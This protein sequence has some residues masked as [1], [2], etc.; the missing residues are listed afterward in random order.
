MDKT[1]IENAIGL[2]G[3]DLYLEVWESW[4][5]KDW[6]WASEVIEDGTKLFWFG[7]LHASIGRSEA[8]Q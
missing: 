6:Q 1:L 7:P 5:L 3:Y 2:F 8:T 4:S